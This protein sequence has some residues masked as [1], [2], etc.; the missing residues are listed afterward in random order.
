MRLVT[1]VIIYRSAVCP[2]NNATYDISSGLKISITENS[3]SSNNILFSQL[4]IFLSQ[5]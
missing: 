2:V 3:D 4:L 1:P 5:N